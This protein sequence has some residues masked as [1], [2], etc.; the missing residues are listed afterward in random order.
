MK[1]KSRKPVKG[2]LQEFK[3]VEITDPAEIAELERRVR[4]A[5]KAMAARE[6]VLAALEN[7]EA[8]RCPVAIAEI[9]GRILT[10][11][12][13]RIR[14]SDGTVNS[15]LEADH[16]HNLPRLLVDFKPELHDY[17]WNV[18]RVCYIER[19]GPEE[20]GDPFE[21]LWNELA[22]H[23]ATDAATAWPDRFM[24]AARR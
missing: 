5:E 2:V 9:I 1:K 22:K 3:L 20:H 23:V 8:I 14:N 7:G 12:L 15:N 10:T 21:P 6:K 17:Y 16:L 13:L 18:E 24:D 4:A 11:G 19:R